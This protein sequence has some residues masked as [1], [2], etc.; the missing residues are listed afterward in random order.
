MSINKI[1]T[2]KDALR[3]LRAEIM[4]KIGKYTE[5]AHKKKSGF[6]PG[7]DYINYA[8]RVFDSA[9]IKNVVDSALDFW[10]TE[11]RFVKTFQDKLAALL[12]VKH[13]LLTNSGS[14][15]NLLAISALTSPKLGNRQLKPGDEVITTAAGF[16][17]TL[18]PIIQN[19][20]V[21]VIIDVELG[22]YNI[23]TGL[24]EKSITKKTK[25]IFI[26]HTLG[27]PAD[28]TKLG[29]LAKKY[30]LWLVEDNC[31]ALGAKYAGKYTGT[32][33][34]IA[35]FSFYPAHHITM[36]EG[37]A[38]VTNNGL[39]K[40]LISSFKDWGRD[41]WCLPGHDDTCKNRFSWKFDGLPYGYD[42][43]YVYSHI[44]YNLKLT[45]MQA[46]IGVAQLDKLAG[47][48][49]KRSEN[50]DALY[51]GLKK[52][53]KYLMMPRSEQK[54]VPSWFGFPILV[55]EPAPFTR[56]DIVT[57]LEDNKIATR[58]LFGGNLL[59]QPA[60]KNVKCRVAGKLSNTDLVMTNMFWLGVYPGITKDM[61]K[62]IIDKF[63]RFIADKC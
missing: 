15:A 33:G 42:H 53:N 61:I 46:A 24:I 28:L 48:I 37:G 4:N 17:S 40:I 1:D 43:K 31:D 18:N 36:G 55:N 23:N 30:N 12:R 44:G 11:G 49:N 2:Q 63:D 20:L 21:P 16:P 29:M 3:A 25:A 39:L 57:Y 58:L 60:Y 7:T 32:F 35:T 50:F 9:E 59:R 38:L 26:A 52:H 54:A 62:Y 13:C 19:R 22:T 14:S 8:G 34:D 10:L 6:K 5:I 27:N 45:E 47:F 56:N 41:C 51:A